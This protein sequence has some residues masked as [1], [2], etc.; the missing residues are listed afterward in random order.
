MHLWSAI[1]K[2]ASM[3]RSIQ[4]LSQRL[5]IC[6]FATMAHALSAS[7]SLL[8]TTLFGLVLCPGETSIVYEGTTYNIGDVDYYHFTSSTG[9]DSV[10][11]IVVFQSPVLDFWATTSPICRGSTDGVIEMWD[12]VDITAPYEF[13]LDGGLTY[14]DEYTYPGLPAG[15]YELRARNRFGCVFE[16]DLT[17]PEYPPLK[18]QAREAVVGCTDSVQLD[19]S[20]EGP[21]TAGYHWQ[22]QGGGLTSTDSIF[23][24]KTP[25]PYLLTVANQC[26]TVQR[27]I[28]VSMEEGP[29][30][31]LFY[32]P[33]VFS[34]NGDG[35]NDCLKAF[36]P[37]SFQML[38]FQLLV[39]DRWGGE[40]FRSN[41]PDGCWDGTWRG[42]ELNPAT[43]IWQLNIRLLDCF[44]K[45]KLVVKKGEVSLLR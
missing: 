6:C 15:H 38:D 36:L 27:K 1:A 9:L 4:N 29:A 37:A 19:F 35:I 26:D 20:I 18:V 17:I 42:K 14:F 21:P 5:F 24:A 16:Y 8:D 41:E 30:E 34:P 2:F 32:A 33:N 23:W 10:V 25:G 40:V 31:L 39:F 11:K 7:A 44:G 43:F 12:N 22:W 13:S 3:Y 45:E 28:Q